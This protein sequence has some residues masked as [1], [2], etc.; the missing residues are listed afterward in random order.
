MR[1]HAVVGLAL[2]VFFRFAAFAFAFA[3]AF[4]VCRLPFTGNLPLPLQAA[5]RFACRLSPA[6]AVVAVV[7]RLLRASPLRDLPLAPCPACPRSRSRS[8][9]VVR[10]CWCW[11]LSGGAWWWWWW[12]RRGG[13]CGRGPWTSC[14]ITQAKSGD[15][16]SL[17][18]LKEIIRAAP[19]LFSACVG[20]VLVNNISA[21]KISRREVGGPAQRLQAAVRQLTG[22][23]STPAALT[24]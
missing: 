20:M 13:G 17:L 24:S 4:A 6:P 19:C 7:I 15:I 12:W 16:D 18:V 1:R 3:F 5:S 14:A 23:Q 21:R 22:E 8:W 11:W 9:L 2:R 10:W